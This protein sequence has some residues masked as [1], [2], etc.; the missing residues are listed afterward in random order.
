MHLSEE[1]SA[2][3][4]FFAFNSGVFSQA[5]VRDAE[6]FAEIAE[7][8]VRLAVKVGTLQGAAE[9]L[10]QAMKSRTAIDIARGI[11]IAQNRCTQSEARKILVK[12]SSTRNQKLRDLAEEIVLR[13]SGEKPRT[14]F[15]NP[16]IQSQ[17]PKDRHVAE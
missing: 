17:S 5:I 4:N 2:A 14:H 16:A 10:E 15:D 8:A 13:A 9:N 3:L 12:A 7:H 6:G 1:A 11:I